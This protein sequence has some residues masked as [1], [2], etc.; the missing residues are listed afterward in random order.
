MRRFFLIIKLI[1]RVKIIF[2]EPKNYKLVIFDEES[3]IDIKNVIK[4]F[5]YFVIQNRIDHINK[6]YISA[7]IIKL[8]KKNYKGNIMTS[9][10]VSLLEI[11]KPKAVIT[12]IDN[13]EKFSDLAKILKKKIKFVAIQNAYRLDIMENNYLYKNRLIGND[14]NKELCIP[15]FLCLGQHSIELYKKFKIK[16]KNFF[17]VGSLRLSNSL[18]YFK[19]NKINL[20]SYKYDVCLI[21]DTTHKAHFKNLNKKYE[22]TAKYL[23]EGIAST[24]K[25]T[26]KFCMD[27][28][29]KFIFVSKNKKEN[30]KAYNRELNFYKKYLSSKEFNFLILNSAK[31]KSN[32][33]DSYLAMF[34]SKVT[35]STISTMLGENLALGNKILACNQTRLS[36]LD[37]PIE[38]ICSLKNCKY[39]I[40]EKKLLYILSISNKK[41]LTLLRKN[42]NYLISYNKKKSTIEILKTYIERLIN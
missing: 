18:K 27:H 36:I 29:K 12:F 37:F 2:K 16:A 5:D 40:F 30:Y 13:S 9:Y 7:K 41:F 6:I 28:K 19:K 31:N 35:V 24:V 23:D 11:I 15:N 3:I 21:S 39:E 26:I 38:G 10:F 34:K 14:L 1:F 32:L 17:I 8:I 42:K 4:N 22:Y 25:Y 33:F 20:K